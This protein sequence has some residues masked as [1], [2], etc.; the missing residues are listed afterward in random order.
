MYVNL[1]AHTIYSVLDGHA[2][3]N[4]Y[5]KQIK[6]VG[7]SHAA[8]TDHGTMAGIP[9]FVEACKK[10]DVQPI[11]GMEAY[12][13]AEGRFIPQRLN[14][15]LTLIAINETGYKNLIRLSTLASTEGFYYKPRI[16]WE[17]LAKYNEGLVVLSGCVSGELGY[18]INHDQ[19]H[20]VKDIVNFYQDVFKDR[21]FLEFMHHGDFEEQIKLNNAL[22][23]IARKTGI[24]SVATND[25]HFCAARDYAAQ[26]MLI[27]VRVK[28]QELGSPYCYVRDNSEM[29][30]IFTPDQLK[31][32]LHI[33][34]M[35]EKYNLGSRIPRLPVTPYELGTN[36]Y[37]MLAKMSEEGL[38][39]RFAF[40]PVYIER[41]ESEL[42]VIKNLSQ[43]LG[44]DFS[45]YLL[46]IAD[47]VNYCRE[48]NIR[49]G[50]RGSAAGSVICWALGISEPDPIVH[51]LYFE[52]FLN[53]YRVEMPDIDLDFA[54][55]RREEVFTYIKTVYGEDN[56]ARIGTYNAIGTKQALRDA[57]REI[58]DASN[59]DNVYEIVEQMI[60]SI[61]DDPRPGG[62]PLHEIVADGR[63]ETLA[64]LANREPGKTILETALN[65]EGR[66]RG[67]GMHAA[68]VVIADI[69]LVDVLP[70][71]RTKDFKDAPIKMQT[72]YE[73]QHLEN[74]GLLK[75]DILGLK[76][77]ST[78]N[79]TLERVNSESFFDHVDPWNIPW[80]NTATWELIKEGHTLAC[81]Q[82]GSEG[83]NK[84]CQ[85]MQ[86]NS[87]ED[88]AITIA[89]YRPG[90]L[91]NFSH[92]VNRKL[93]GEPIASIHPAIDYILKDTYGFPVYQEQV[94]EIARVFAGYTLGE[95]DL[96]RKAMGKKIREKM[97]EEQIRF[98]AGA[99]N[100]G[101]TEEE[102]S[103]VWDYLLP[104]ANYGFNKAHAI[105]YAYVAYQTAYLKANY[106]FSFYASAMTVEA[107]TGGTDNPQQ[108]IG[109]LVREARKRNV[110]IVPPSID[111]PTQ[112]FEVHSGKIFYGFGAIKDI[113]KNDIEK[114]INARKNGP[115]TSLED[116][117]SRTKVTV[118][119]AET[120][121]AIGALPWHNRATLVE[122]QKLKGPRGGIKEMSMIGW[123]KSPTVS[124]PKELK[125]WSDITKLKHEVTH[126]GMFT[127]AIPM[128]HIEC[129][130]I[131]DI[132]EDPDY[133][134]GRYVT[135]RCVVLKTG[136]GVFK[137]NNQTFGKC[138][139]LDESN[140]E[141]L[142]FMYPKQYYQEKFRKEMYV[143]NIVLINGEYKK[144]MY[145][146]K[147]VIRNIWKLSGE[148]AC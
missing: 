37:D 72:Q 124:E 106:P 92:I 70:L 135:L 114:M 1:H 5:V 33:A 94:M 24:P 75:V 21:Y 79:A 86:P 147:V 42:S 126:L 78:L 48:N 98:F 31:N 57:G 11:V 102:A 17:L 25:S 52:R 3:I 148:Q 121:A 67:E 144:D 99:K 89:V 109:Q 14:N 47:I 65:L 131:Q 104:F 46:M 27:R 117:L 45:R 2:T 16:D 100:N 134:N 133:Y 120:L 85:E 128:S 81:F 107:N 6:L 125:E 59:N 132:K 87:I 13:H 50:P 9:A 73:M 20:R 71:Q 58:R 10:H 83:L 30:S 119:T 19:E 130:T 54:D 146:E 38:A 29:S 22:I 90:P 8:I 18:A 129:V 68:G 69:P 127:T 142:L 4:D 145:G 80:N 64:D 101:H 141:M 77:L 63:S 110:E 40:T 49:F 105:C 15:H 36:A 41:L 136:T 97:A 35:V 7:H 74:L 84:A 76:T 51:G 53:P 60:K 103:A 138:F 143:G 96:L 115:Y 91:Q 118:K 88:L 116:F 56:V 62:I 28:D 139:V 44:A 123:I 32:T 108:R 93:N 140:E 113:N 82:I 137:N 23:E 12:I 26:Q 34:S 112:D 95:A 122:K 66:L 55:D 43:K 111:F 61:P 39:Q